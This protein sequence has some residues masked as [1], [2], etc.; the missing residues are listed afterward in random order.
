MSDDIDEKQPSLLD[1]GTHEI[2]NAQYY[3]LSNNPTELKI[4]TLEMLYDSIGYGQLAYMDAKDAETGEIIPLLIGLDPT[5]DGKFKLFP[6]AELVMG[7][8]LQRKYLVPDGR[9][10]YHD[11]VGESVDLRGESIE[12]RTGEEE[13]GPPPEATIN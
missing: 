5:D 10:N 13:T 11:V 8:A 12:S 6:L 1:E 3:V 7:N 9:G 4:K 2:S